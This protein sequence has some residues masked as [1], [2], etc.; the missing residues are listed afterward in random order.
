MNTQSTPAIRI[1]GDVIPVTPH[2]EHEYTMPT[3]A[4]AV[5]YGISEVTLRRHKKEH[6]DELL[7]GKH[8]TSVQNLN[9]G[10][11]QRVTTIWTKRGIIRLGFFIKSE[12]AKRFRDMAEDLILREWERPTLAPDPSLIF[13]TLAMLAESTRVIAAGVCAINGRLDGI[14]HRL[15]NLEQSLR[16]AATP[17]PLTLPSLAEEALLL[18]SDLVAGQN[19]TFDV[20]FQQIAAAGRRL[21][22][23]GFELP[24]F[25]T[26][27]RNRKGTKASQSA[28]G[29]QAARLL[30]T[31]EFY[32]V[33]GVM[34]QVRKRPTGRGSHY[35]FTRAKVAR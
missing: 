5:G 18:V 22:L 9:A 6:A 8:F 33:D 29:K 21:G 26:R 1:D 35:R 11:L 15:A 17:T 31:R 12:R 19:G 34:W 30:R 2:P 28:L 4:V 13:P 27:V 10:N 32:A 23:D 3:A 25:P 20:S 14:D 24:D 16:P 7:E